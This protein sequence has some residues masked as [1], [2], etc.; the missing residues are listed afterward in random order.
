MQL[1][2]LAHFSCMAQLSVFF[3]PFCENN[4][5]GRILAASYLYH[6]L[7][8]DTVFT[9]TSQRAFV[10]LNIALRVVLFKCT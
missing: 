10:Y 8:V 9:V 1:N 5:A 4:I 7:P 6:E 3:C 2:V